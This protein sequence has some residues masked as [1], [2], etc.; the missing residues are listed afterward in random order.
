MKKD[1]VI[2]FGREKE[3]EFV[4][5]DPEGI[6][7]VSKILDG[8]L[9]TEA[10]Y[11]LEVTSTRGTKLVQVSRERYLEHYISWASEQLDNLIEAK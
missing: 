2:T 7:E 3:I 10:P 8:A 9:T 4:A 5:H 6:L 11:I 1:N